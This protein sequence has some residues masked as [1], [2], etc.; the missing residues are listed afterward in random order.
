[1]PKRLQLKRAFAEL[2]EELLLIIVALVILGGIALF[3]LR[4]L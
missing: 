3:Y 4:E 2:H 1:M